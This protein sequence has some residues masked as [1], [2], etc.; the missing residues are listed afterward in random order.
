MINSES[1][2][3]VMFLFWSPFHNDSFLVLSYIT[4]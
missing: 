2:V 1:Y 3:K 4:N